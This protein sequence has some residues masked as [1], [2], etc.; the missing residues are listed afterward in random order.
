MIASVAGK[1]LPVKLVRL[2]GTLGGAS[3][4]P[5]V[6]GSGLWPVA[7]GDVP[8]SEKSSLIEG[9]EDIE[10]GMGKLEV[11]WQNLEKCRWTRTVD[12]EKQV[13]CGLFNACSEYYG[14]AIDDQVDEER[15]TQWDLVVSYGNILPLG[16]H[17]SFEKKQGCEWGRETSSCVAENTGM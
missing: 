7:D 10:D 9:L 6:G 13:A 16:N 11:N 4:G 5:V 14:H 12:E 17:P 3:S 15:R 8:M 1:L 2:R